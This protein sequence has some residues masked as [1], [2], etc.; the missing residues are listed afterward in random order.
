MTAETIQNKTQKTDGKIIN[1]ASGCYE[2]SS[3]QPMEVQLD[4]P[5]EKKER[6]KKMT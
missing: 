1:R 5:K 4:I 2:G 6:T 3:E